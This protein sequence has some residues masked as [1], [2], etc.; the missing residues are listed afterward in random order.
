MMRR[1]P[2]LV[3]T[4]ARTAVV[5]GTASA[6]SGR[7]HHRQA[8]RWETEAAEE[9]EAAD[10]A[11][12]QQQIAAQQSQEA[13]ATLSDQPTAADI[14]AQLGQLGQLK[15]SGVLTE[16]EFAAAKAKLLG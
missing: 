3:R 15:A 14:T 4:M 2:G 10:A 1:G 7:V 6:V 8:E 5:A 11:E 9:P 16:E 12:L 13:R